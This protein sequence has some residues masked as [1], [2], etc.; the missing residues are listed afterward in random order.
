[1]WARE[2]KTGYW[3]TKEGIERLNQHIA[4]IN[5]SDLINVRL[6][7][8]LILEAIP[9][10]LATI[11]QQNAWLPKRLRMEEREIKE[12]KGDEAHLS[13]IILEDDDDE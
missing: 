9:D 10:L 3:T 12:E 5:N 6:W 1:M 4:E 11:K 2:H 7:R 13:N 8:I